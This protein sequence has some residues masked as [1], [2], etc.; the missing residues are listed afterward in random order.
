[1]RWKYACIKSSEEFPDALFFDESINEKLNRSSLKL[2]K[3]PT[4]FLLSREYKIVD[5]FICPSPDMTG[6][7][8]GFL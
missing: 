6:L 4:D 2:N 5:V 7:D 1:M 8:K 3:L